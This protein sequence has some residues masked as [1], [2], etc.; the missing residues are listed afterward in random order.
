MNVSALVFIAALLAQAAPPPTPGD[1]AFARG[2]FDAAFAAYSATLSAQPGDVDATIGIG[3]I[4]LYRNDLSDARIYLERAAKLDPS[5]VPVRARLRALASREPSS[6]DFTIAMTRAVVDLPF[7]ATDPLP[8]VRAKINGIEGLFLLDTGADTI[9][10]TSESAARFHIASHVAGQGV[11]AGGKGATVSAG[12]IDRV[13]VDGLSVR[14][15]PT[16][17]L[18]SSIDMAGHRLDGAIGTVFLSHFLS[19]IDYR[20][21]QLV[22]RPRSASAAFEASAVSRGATV[23]PMWLVGDHFLFTRAHVNAG[24]EALFNVD[25]GGG[26]LGVQLTKSALVA[27]SIRIPNASKSTSFEGG[28]GAASAIP[29]TAAAVTVGSTTRTN[30]PG[31]YFDKGD[32][33]GIFPFAVAGT[34][35]HAFFRAGSVTFDF[36]AMKMIVQ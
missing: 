16:N 13:D 7:V 25:T 20:G 8:M 33:Y 2:D 19:T 30:L 24:P 29:F 27:A 34:I 15:I 22:L 21:K 32:Q 18:P 26:G 4:D 12:R 23:V 36:D 10:L 14:G 17:I 1:A 35:S 6:A 31:L 5:S 9:D 28:G 11:F 3:T